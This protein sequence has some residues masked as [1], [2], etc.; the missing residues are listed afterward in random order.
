MITREKLESWYTPRENVARHVPVKCEDEEVKIEIEK[1][2]EICDDTGTVPIY[3]RTNE[4]NYV[5]D[6]DEPCICQQRVNNY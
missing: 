6:G 2:C 4:G 3:T 1:K 5:W